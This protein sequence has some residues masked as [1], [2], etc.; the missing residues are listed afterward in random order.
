[1]LGDSCLTIPENPTPRYEASFYLDYNAIKIANF[2]D[3]GLAELRILSLRHNCLVEV[4]ALSSLRKLEELNLSIN[5][6]EEFTFD[7]N[8]HVPTLQKLDLSANRLSSTRWTN[9]HQLQ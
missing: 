9:P 4:A 2:K 5:F 7:G 1:M 6:L 8:N 3:S